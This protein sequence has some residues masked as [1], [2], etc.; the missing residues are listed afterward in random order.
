MIRRR[1]GL[2]LPLAEQARVAG[3]VFRKKLQ[4]YEAPQAGVFGLV[5]H[6]HPATAARFDRS[7]AVAVLARNRVRRSLEFGC[8]I[9]T[10]R[11]LKSN[12]H[13]IPST[14]YRSDRTRRAE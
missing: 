10:N 5:K 11:P 6:A 3:D 12:S 14:T 1:R 4:G 7:G 9:S 13:F 2:G 8:L